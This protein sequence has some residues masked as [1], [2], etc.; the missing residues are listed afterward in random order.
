MAE[1]P[2]NAALIGTGMV[3]GAFATALAD[4][5]G[6]IRLTRVLARRLQSAERFADVHEA[7]LSIRPEPVETVA[8]I[9]EDTEIDFVILATPPDQR[10]EIVTALTAAGKPILME[11]P[12]ERTLAAARVLCDMA[13]TADV[14]LGIVLQHRVRPSARRL[15]TW[16]KQ[17]AP[18]PLR[19]VEIA[20]PWWRPQ[21]YYDAPGRGTYARD[22]GGVLITQAIHSLDLALAFTP[23]VIEVTA[24][25]ATSG[26]HEMEAEDFVSAGLRFDG[27]GVGTL[28]A[29]TAAYPGRSEEIRLHYR[30]ASVALRAAELEIHRQDGTSETIGTASAS[31]SGADPMAFTSDWHR[32]VISDFAKAVRT[33]RPPVAP[34]R[35]A[36]AAHA[37]IDA[38]ERSARTGSPAVPEATE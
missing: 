30:D 3:S 15:R 38:I 29:T 32:D 19:A 21:G 33:G 9:A 18:G 24:M 7:A 8:E 22:G 27:G 25:A 37:L 10:L 31:G 17:S 1:R 11:K 20:V 5:A 6:D 4:L 13:D 28:F 16:L 12:I 26:F 23:A 2:M 14:P 35:S 36:L 34:A